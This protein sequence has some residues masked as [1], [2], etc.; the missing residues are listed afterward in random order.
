MTKSD[1]AVK[2]LKSYADYHSGPAKPFSWADIVARVDDI[3][4]ILAEL[5]DL[6]KLDAEYGRVEFAILMA[7]QDFDGDSDHE[8]C[9]DRLVTSVERFS[10]KV[11]AQAA[12][13][14][15]LRESI[16][17]MITAIQDGQIDSPELGGQDDIPVH[18]WHEEWLYHAEQSMKG[19]E[20]E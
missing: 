16:T 19:N 10:E 9:G 18:C 2:R 1:D 3:R 11:K 15:R 20:N 8:N 7:D 17:E 4:T 13:I 12:E 6:R 14:E 5:E